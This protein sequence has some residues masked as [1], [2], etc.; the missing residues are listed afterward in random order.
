PAFA[1][2]AVATLALGIGANTAIFSV[3][4]GVLL[5]P[6]PFPDPDRLGQGGITTPQDAETLVGYRQLGGGADYSKV[7]EGMASTG[8]SSRNLQGVADPEQVQTVT[9]ERNL[10]RLLRV[11]ASAGRVFGEGDPLNVVVATAG[12]AQRHFGGEQPAIG[13][14]IILDGA[15]F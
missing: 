3:A 9:A 14:T 2:A 15:Q 5:R 12:F 1:I 8:T 7:F 4:N 11:D 6:L 13:R 10:F